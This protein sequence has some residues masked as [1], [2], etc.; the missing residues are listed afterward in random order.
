MYAFIDRPVTRLGAGS[1]FILW[2]MRASANAERRDRCPRR[3]IGGSFVNMGAGAALVDFDEAMAV[4]RR[5]P[6]QPLAFGAVGCRCIAEGEAL[7]LALWAMLAAG[8]DDLAL[9][10]LR[11]MIPA[12]AADRVIE[13]LAAATDHL[14][15]ADLLPAGLADTLTQSETGGDE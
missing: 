10:T 6:G 13:S 11:L 2:A 3:A 5:A 15:S 1:R 12:A 8:K 4:L 14:R 7:M 9:A